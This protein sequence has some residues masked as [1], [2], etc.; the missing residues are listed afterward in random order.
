MCYLPG[1]L[2]TLY[3][4]R[5]CTHTPC[6]DTACTLRHCH[7]ASLAVTMRR[8]STAWQMQL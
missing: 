4:C 7:V 6:V 2:R 8:I 1:L 3:A 5:H